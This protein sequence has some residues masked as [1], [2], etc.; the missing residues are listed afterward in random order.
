MLTTPTLD[1]LHALGLGGMARA[2]HEQ[3][4]RPDHQ[5]LSFEERLGLLVD[6]EALDRDNRRLERNLKTAKLRSSACLEDVDFR[7]PRGLDRSLLLS[8]ASA[9]WVRAHHCCLIVGPTGVGKTYIACALA[10]AAIRQGHTALYLRAPRLLSELAL[11]KADGR[12]RRLMAAWARVDVLVIDDFA[13][14]P[15]APEQAADLFEVIEDR[16]QL[17]STIVTSQ[18]PVKSWHDAL[19]EPTIA[20]AILDR[21]VH[22]SHRI[23]LGGDSLRKPDQPIAQTAPSPRAKASRAADA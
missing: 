23:E 3:L 20:D 16:S 18:L 9:Q 2:L 17:R 13:L 22:N 12:L 1:K 4:E 6:R 19:G 5:G 8:L 15:L 11:A 10:Q 21:L 14:R 7:H